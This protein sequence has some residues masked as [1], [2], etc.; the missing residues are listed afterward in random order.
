M[1]IGCRGE[2]IF[3]PLL[4]ITYL[5]ALN[6]DLTKGLLD[7]VTV[8]VS[9]MILLGQVDDKKIITGLYNVAH[10]STRGQS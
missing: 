2:V 4:A 7:L 9:I 10:D 5:Q 3:N 6:F 1:Y 8:Y